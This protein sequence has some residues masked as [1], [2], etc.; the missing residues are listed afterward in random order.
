MRSDAGDYILKFCALADGAYS[1]E[2][3]LYSHDLRHGRRST[4]SPSPAAA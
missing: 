4:T 1:D 3:G 2:D